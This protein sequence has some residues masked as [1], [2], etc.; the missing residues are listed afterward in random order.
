M[1]RLIAAL[2]AVALVSPPLATRAAAQATIAVVSPHPGE[3]VGTSTYIVR[4]SAPAIP[5]NAGFVVHYINGAGE[6]TPICVAPPA[7]RQCEWFEPDWY[8][9]AL[10]V[11]ARDSS[12]ATLATGRSGSF[13]VEWEGLPQMFHS[14]RDIGNVG[15]S[16]GAWGA[17]V[18]GVD[19]RGAGGDIWGTA[20]AFH[21]DYNAWENGDLNAS[22][23]ITGVDGAH[24]WTKAGVM[25]RDS[26]GP[27]STHHSVFAT[28]GKGVA[29]QRRLTQDGPTLHTTVSSDST[30]PVQV[31]VMRR[32]AHIV[33]DV[34]QGTGAWQ[35]VAQF[36]Q[37]NFYLIGMAVTSHDTTRLA[38]GSFRDV[39]L[40][41]HDATVQILSPNGD[42]L[43]AG[44]PY[45][46]SWTH[47]Q[48]VNVA[49]VSY[50]V[51]DGESWTVIPG[52]ASI[53]ATT[54]RWS[55]PG[56]VTE[57]ALVKVVVEDPNDRTAWNVSDRFAVRSN[58]DSALPAGWVSG[59]VGAVSAAGA[60][61]YDAAIGQF[62][63]SGSGADI[64]GRADEFHYASRRVYEEGAFGTDITV[65][66]A[67]VENV[68][69]WTK[70]GLMLRQGRGA[71]AAHLS[72]FTTPSTV[73]GVALQGRPAAGGTSLHT[74]GPA[75]TAPVWLKFIV[76][77]GTAR[78]YY[79]KLATD[80]WTFIAEQP[81]AMAAPYE[82]GL[83]VSSH[84]DGQLAR[85]TFDN[86]SITARDFTNADIGAVGVAGATGTND[87]MRT[88]WGSGG[89]IWGTADAFRY[90]Y[91][92]ME[93]SGAVSARVTSIQPT[94]PWAKAGVMIRQDTSAGS[95]HVM[96]VASP[97]KGIAMQYRAVPNGPTANVAIVPGTAPV[98]LRLTRRGGSV[99]GERSSD[100]VSWS[101]VGRVDVAIGQFVT[102]GLAVTSHV[103][104]RLARGEFEDVVLQP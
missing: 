61:S 3:R 73:K 59:D 54:C 37:Y 84:V 72:L 52:C 43:T 9:T 92:P 80:P 44:V 46:V 75:I 86:L 41:L 18:D 81:V 4:W 5:G 68:N 12:G 95:P 87:I 10:S 57:A 69:A 26:G 50:S 1:M 79:R 70:E 30:L 20:D 77:G 49:T 8:A 21:F 6:E 82:A 56:P 48:P 67:S 85:A 76:G 104:N 13:V 91:Q 31:Q 35:R 93:T 2:A 88:L 17:G 7:A 71:G 58:S 11:D 47:V 27:G 45:T 36:R 64:W 65:R 101:E 97:G 16:G 98:W 19:V 53:A 34:R 90:H 33:M 96:L 40:D 62:T 51:D 102:A 22:F 55:N 29:Y 100:G 89:D 103:R 99:L 32:N 74:S 25:L 60:A 39:S 83:A 38:T 63:V 15:R 42:T 28:K 14:H 24:P 94:D 23:T 66:V 78:A